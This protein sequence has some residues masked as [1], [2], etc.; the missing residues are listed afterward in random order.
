M[1]CDNC[2][3]DI[4]AHH[5]YQ[6]MGGGHGEVMGCLEVVDMDKKTLCDCLL[7]PEEVEAQDD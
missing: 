2:G 6:Y 3:H 1:N 5:G 4:S 7:S